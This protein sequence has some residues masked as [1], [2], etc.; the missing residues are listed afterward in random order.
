MFKAEV[1][2][3]VGRAEEAA[4]EKAA[5]REGTEGGAELEGDDVGAVVAP[6]VVVV[7]A[8]IAVVAAGAAATAAPPLSQGFGGEGMEGSGQR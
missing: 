1:F 7:A 2:A 3:A 8:G 5:G 4:V 6:G